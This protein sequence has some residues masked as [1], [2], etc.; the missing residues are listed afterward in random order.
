M[1]RYAHH[2]APNARREDA[3]TLAAFFRAPSAR[4]LSAFHY[5]RRAWGLPAAARRDMLRAA[6]TPAAFARWPGIAGCATRMLSMCGCAAAI[7]DATSTPRRDELAA[8][9]GSD[10]G[11]DDDS[12]ATAEF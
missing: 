1:R 8:A 9:E 5:G 7:V 2:E 11:G 12:D 3:R 6:R 10:G 4:L